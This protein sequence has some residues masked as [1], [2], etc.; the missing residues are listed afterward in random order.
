M[1]GHSNK[2]A[3]EIL[4]RHA[5]FL[6]SAAPGGERLTGVLCSREFAVPSRLRF[7]LAGHGSHPGKPPN[8]KKYVQLVEA[9]TGRILQRTGCSSGE[10]AQEI[11]WDLSAFTGRRACF[12]IVDRD[13]RGGFAW[14]AAGGFEPDIAPLPTMAP[15][16]LAKRQ[17]AAAQIARDLKLTTVLDAATGLAT[18][19]IAATAAREVAVSAIL[20]NGNAD[21]QAS[22]A[23]IL[24]DGGQPR[25]LRLAVANGG[26]HLPVVRS[27]LAKALGQAPADLQLQ[28]ALALVRNRLGAKALLGIVK[29]GQAP[30]GL[31]LDPQIKSS[32]PKAAAQ[33]VAALTADLPKPTADR[34]RLIAERVAAFRETGGDAVSGRTTFATYC[35]ACHQK[36][37][38]GGNI[39]P[40]LDGA[41][42]RGVERLV[43][44][45]LDPN[46]NVDVAFRY[47]IVKLKKGQTVLGLKRREVGESLVFADLA[48]AESSIAKADIASQEQTSR[49]LMPEALGQ[50]IPPADFSNL[51]EF[52]FAK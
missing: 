48:G 11:V 8:Q 35:A 38:E 5:D 18:D 26:A 52:L 21:Q 34:E 51:L 40:Q 23:S 6:S 41:G 4:T 22:V 3:L 36:G 50:A 37:G 2:A 17:L 25:S 32:F 16:Y 15:R 46:R 49:S 12:E 27:R 30:A 10:T 24:E 39:G 19:P 14:V 29:S 42:N 44:D 13:T 9:V 20:G 1:D 31:L 47:S 33:R 45:I 28:F 43:E 7:L